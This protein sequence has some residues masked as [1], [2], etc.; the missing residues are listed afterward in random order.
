MKTERKVLVDGVL[1]PVILSDEQE[2]LLAAK[3]AGRVFVGLAEKGGAARLWGA[4]YVAEAEPERER[5]NNQKD[6][7][8]GAA[9]TFLGEEQTAEDLIRRAG[10]D[11]V[12][13]E[14]IVR[15]SLGLPWRICETERLLIREF[16]KEDG[17]RVLKEPE[18][19]TESDRVFYTPELLDAYIRHQ[20]RFCEYGIWAVVRKSDGALVG[21]AGV[22]AGQEE[23]GQKSAGEAEGEEEAWLELGYHVFLPDP[24]SS[25]AGQ[26]SVCPAFKDAW[27]TLLFCHR[28]IKDIANQRDGVIGSLR[29]GNQTKKRSIL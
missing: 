8:R 24:G 29:T 21:T 12:Y 9:G 5:E 7:G 16:T 10:V 3:A 14:R 28:G 18:E 23:D 6:A 2:T 4:E 20:Y 15:R 19:E 11:D 26:H 17:T 25:K 27:N 13:L 22:S 1:Y